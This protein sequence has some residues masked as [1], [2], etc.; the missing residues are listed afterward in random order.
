MALAPDSRIE[1]NCLRRRAQRGRRRYRPGVGPFPETNFDAW[2]A[3]DVASFAKRYYEPLWRVARLDFPGID[4]GRAQDL[5]QAFLLRELTRTPLFER[6]DPG[7]GARFRALL[8]TAFW[9][10]ARD[11]LEQEGRRA[12]VALHDVAEP[13]DRAD[14]FDRFVARDFLNALRADVEPTIGDD[15]L[16]RAFFALKWPHQLEVEPLADVEIARRL[17]LTRKQVRTVKE[18]VLTKVLLALRRRIH[19][20]GLRAGDLDAAI[21]DYWGILGRED[22][23]ACAS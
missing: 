17:D 16:E 1:R 11:Q 18:R 4:V 15:G 22:A 19:D 20:D 3:R 23:G 6:F 13:P 21:E 14:M 7:H 5:V 8:R 12:T 10:F 2:T 9:R